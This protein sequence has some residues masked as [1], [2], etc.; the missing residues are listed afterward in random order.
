MWVKNNDTW[1]RTVN[2]GKS[3]CCGTCDERLGC[4]YQCTK[5]EAVKMDPCTKCSYTI[6]MDEYLKKLE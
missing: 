3:G 2:C 1:Y 5:Q 6:K 4:N